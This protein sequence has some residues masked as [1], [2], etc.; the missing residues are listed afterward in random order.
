L[1]EL[2]CNAKVNQLKKEKER[3]EQHLP[4]LKN[5]GLANPVESARNI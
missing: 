4:N 5:Y 2:A 1:E 3:N